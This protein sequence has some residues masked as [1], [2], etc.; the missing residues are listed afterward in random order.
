MSAAVVLFSTVS[1]LSLENGKRVVQAGLLTYFLDR[2]GPDAVHFAL[3]ASPHDPMPDLPCHVHRLDKPRPPEQLW[4][5]GWQAVVR[6][7]RSLQEATFTSRAL[8]RG[9]KRIVADL[10]PALELYDTVRLGQ[11]RPAGSR[12]AQ[13]VLYLDDLFSV[14][15]ER[16]LATAAQ[17]DA[18]FDALGEFAANLPD[19]L[20]GI[21]RVPVVTRAL[22]RFERRRIRQR[23]DE[24]ARDF[25]TSLLVSAP[26]VAQ[27]R[28]RT[29]LRSVRVL[30]PA[31]QTP[32]TIPAARVP[33][34]EFVFLGRL[35]I[36]HNHD[37]IATFLRVVMG[38]LVERCPES[39]VRLIGK[40][41]SPALAQLAALWPDHVRLHG[42]VDDL[43]PMLAR[44][45]A[46]LAPLRFG[47]GIKL[48]V[49]DG[50]ARGLPVVGTTTAAEG[51]PVR[52]KG[53][54]GFVVEDDLERW[55]E[56]LLGVAQADA[57]QI[58]SQAA[59]DFF[60]RTYSRS[61][62]YEQY[63][64]VFA[65]ALSGWRMSQTVRADQPPSYRREVD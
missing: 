2:F 57:N 5:A 50:L 30:T 1:P 18:D 52:P 6:R 19:S 46:L 36:P 62:V 34:P 20:V 38:P 53:A 26:E 3:V 39:R 16:M 37:A 12:P 47:S 17:G 45:S 63:D 48:K 40:G 29:G 28:A 49:L 65:P 61:V 27:L 44:A 25:D 59:R 55:P 31:V 43:D 7:R 64:D 8:R 22:L 11:H 24:V 51:I 33:G 21:V 10:E 9:I 42:F 32:R 13:R 60:A 56:I 35:N 58:L 14:R 15:Y 41:A 54:D 4:N 23:E